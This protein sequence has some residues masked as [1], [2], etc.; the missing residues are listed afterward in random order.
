MVNVNKVWE[1]LNF[2]LNK[3]QEGNTITPAEIN[4][5]FPMV[6]V[7][8]FKQRYGLPEEYKPG[9]PLPKMSYEVTQKITDDLRAFKVRM[10]TDVAAMQLDSLGRAPI[11]SNY[12]HFSSVRYNMLAT[13]TCDAST[14][15][16]R[17]IEHLSDAQVGDR[18]GNSIKM[19][20]ARNPVFV[21]YATYFQFYPKDLRN[22]EFT[23]LKMPAT[24]VYGFTEDDTTDEIT[25]SATASTHF[26]YPEDCFM[27]IV[28]M[29]AS[30][31]GMNLEDD[32]MVQFAEMQ[33]TKGV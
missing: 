23:Y 32:R 4:I 24:P 15:K 1:A 31:A 22:I 27:D 26:E 25:Y 29:C 11:P 33:K 17:S 16:P 18:L 5:L 28:R 12:I 8:F 19:P 9:Q 7:D 2:L 6:N 21:T 13:N 14:F 20:T 30:Y 10:G 3:E